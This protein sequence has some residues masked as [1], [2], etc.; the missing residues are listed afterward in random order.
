MGVV[1]GIIYMVTNLLDGRKYIGA[2]S[3]SLSRRKSDHMIKGG[4]GLGSRFQEALKT[5]GKEAFE[6]E[7]IDTATS[8]N[9]LAEKESQ[10]VLQYETQEEGYNTDRGGGFQKS[11]YQYDFETGVILSTF[12]SLLEASLSV[13]VHPK[14]I[15]KACLG[16]IKN[17]R[18]YSWSYTL[19]DR[20]QPDPDRRTK[21]VFQFNTRGGFIDSFDSV[22]EASRATG[23]NKSSI[24][25]CCRGIYS[26]AGD[27][28]WKYQDN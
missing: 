7:Q 20:Y 4:K 28:L 1:K 23:V 17:C 25:K 22:A 26:Y 27:Y 5:Y 16:E 15:S 18:G 19:S 8:L 2:T 12:S 24:A 6:W 10:Y 13:G 14:T 21:K 11:I 9:E 3:D